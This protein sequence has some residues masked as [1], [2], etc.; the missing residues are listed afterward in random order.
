ME[1]HE[2]EL[3]RREE[4]FRHNLGKAKTLDEKVRLIDKREQS[5]K[6]AE[7]ELKQKVKRLED[8]KL[9][10]DAPNEKLSGLRETLDA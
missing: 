3:E 8:K 7:E 5:C 6:E 9:A 1:Q 4:E 10:L 2:K